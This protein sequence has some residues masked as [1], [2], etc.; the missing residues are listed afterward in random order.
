[1]LSSCGGGSVNATAHNS[2]TCPSGGVC[3]GSDKTVRVRSN[4]SNQLAQPAFLDGVA[5]GGGSFVLVG[6]EST[7]ATSP[8]GATWTSAVTTNVNDNLTGIAYGVAIGGNIVNVNGININRVIGTSI[9]VAIGLGGQIYTS[10]D[11]KNWTLSL[12][13]VSNMYNTEDLRGITYGVIAG[14]GTFVAVGNNGSIMTSSDYGNSWNY[15]TAIGTQNA[16]FAVTAANN[17][18]FVAVGES[19]TIITSIDGTTWVPQTSNTPNSLYAITYDYATQKFVAVGENGTIVTSTDASGTNWVAQS[20]GSGSD[21]L[22]G[23]VYSYGLLVAIAENNGGTLWTSTDG[24][25]WSSTTITGYNGNLYGITANAAGQ[26]VVVGES[27]N[28]LV[29]PPG[30]NYTFSQKND[31]GSISTD[32]HDAIY[33]GSDTFIMVGADGIYQYNYTPLANGGNITPRYTASPDNFSAIESGNGMLIAVGSGGIIAR[34]IDNG[35]TWSPES[36]GVTADLNHVA[37]ASGGAFPGFVAG[38]GNATYGS[39]VV[40]YSTDGIIWQQI[41]QMSQINGGLPTWCPVNNTLGIASNNSY[42]VTLEE[43]DPKNFQLASLVSGDPL[44]DG[45]N[46]S[47]GNSWPSVAGATTLNS[48]F[49]ALSQFVTVGNN[50]QIFTS[51]TGLNPSAND[52]AWTQ[53]QSS[54]VQQNLYKG[55]VSGASAAA[56]SGTAMIIVGDNGTIDISD[57]GSIWYAT[58]EKNN[59]GGLITSPLYGVAC[60]SDNVCVV[61]GA[62]GNIGVANTTPQAINLQ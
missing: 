36:S 16:L 11:G 55:A 6:G 8:D 26:I 42:F 43:Y 30:M 1:M 48:L 51:P 50:G 40:L 47:C 54:N 37:Y 9:F 21:T 13:A 20:V 23:V 17:G 58:Q 45:W 44:G 4:G 60:G 24:S 19:G 41:S 62:G 27:G 35:A 22:T 52:L 7:I 59:L 25:S 39:G 10:F 18:T 34:S 5:Y 15:A 38:G 56:P 29:S 46:W 2:E 32:L 53:A 28:T 3:A 33:V 49:Y 12:N 31:T 61:V 14:N 57:N